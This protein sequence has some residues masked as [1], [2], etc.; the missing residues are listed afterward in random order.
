MMIASSYKAHARRR[1]KRGGVQ[2]VVSQA[3]SRQRIDVRCVHR[4]AVTT[5]LAET[6]VIQNNEQHVRCAFSR[7]IGR[8]PCRLRNIE[9]PAYYAWK[10]LSWFVFLERHVDFLSEVRF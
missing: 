5:Q 4:T 6:Y 9:R 1:T 8:R 3:V 2:V 7:T 10:S